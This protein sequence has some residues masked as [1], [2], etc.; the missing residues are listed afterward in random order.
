MAIFAFDELDRALAAIVSG[1]GGSG[2]TVHLFQNNFAFGVSTLLANL[3]EASYLG[4]TPVNVG[5]GLGASGGS[6]GTSTENFNP[7]LFA[8]GILV[9]PQDCFGWYVTDTGSN[10]VGGDNFAS[11]PLNMGGT[12][13]A[14]VITPSVTLS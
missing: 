8:P 9:T 5:T 3:T 12:T 10:L 14:V 7:A 1:F 4:Y 2:L 13:I 6:S 11:P